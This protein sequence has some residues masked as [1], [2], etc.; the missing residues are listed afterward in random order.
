MLYALPL[1]FLIPA[2]SLYDG[3]YRGLR[4]F[5]PLAK[6]SLL[7]GLLALALVY[8]LVRVF[9]LP[10]ALFAQNLYYGILLLGLAWSYRDF[11]LRIEKNV[12]RQIASYAGVIGIIT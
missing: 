8:P 4:Q 9:G 12:L 5:P 2:T 1:V 7:A 6:I 3:I 10:G 11:R